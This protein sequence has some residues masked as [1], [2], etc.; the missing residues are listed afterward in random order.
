MTTLAE[1][2]LEVGRG[3]NELWNARVRRHHRD[4]RR[5]LRHGS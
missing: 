4:S 2:N 1:Q 5:R 3:F